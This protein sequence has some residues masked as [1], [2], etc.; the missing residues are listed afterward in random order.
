MYIPLWYTGFTRFLEG[1]T[2]EAV[3]TR[4]STSPTSLFV[5]FSNK[6]TSCLDQYVLCST[7]WCTSLSRLYL[8]LF[9]SDL[10]K[11]KCIKIRNFI[12]QLRLYSIKTGFIPMKLNPDSGDKLFI[13]IDPFLTSTSAY[14]HDI[15]RSFGSVPF[16]RPDETTW[17]LMRWDTFDNAQG[18]L[19]QWRRMQSPI[20]LAGW[21]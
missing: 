6:A 18:N 11:L 9:D 16:Q 10:I 5:F 14:W 7:I 12:T 13:G 15:H 8:L 4:K 2:S 3:I 17:H 19:W 21:Q 1:M 20:S